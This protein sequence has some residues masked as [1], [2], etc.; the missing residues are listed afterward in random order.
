M[1]ELPFALDRSSNQ[2]LKRNAEVR[3]ASSDRAES[4]NAQER[5]EWVP[6]CSACDDAGAS[7]RRI[8]AL[9]PPNP[10]ELT[11]TIRAP[12][13]AGKGSSLVGTRSFSPAKSMFG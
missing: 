11:P 7:A 4:T 3:S 12:P 13:V 1:G 8:C 9:A 10:N 2:A 5:F 6:K